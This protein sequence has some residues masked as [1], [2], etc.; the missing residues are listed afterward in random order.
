MSLVVHFEIHA[1]DPERLI[2]FYETVFGWTFTRFGDVPYWVINTGEGAVEQPDR[3]GF[4]IN[5]GLTQRIGPAPAVGAPI[6][7][8]NLVVATDDVDALFTKAITSG[9]TVAS[10][11]D[12]M[13]GVGRLAYVL[14]PDHNVIGMIAPPM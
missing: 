7:G 1:S 6:T 10:E 4:G 14:D 13:P 2:T 9:A 8:A 11:P 5:G 12:D 3:P